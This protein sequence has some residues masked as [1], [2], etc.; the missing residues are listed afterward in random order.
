ME[1]V[2]DS[3][4]IGAH[5]ASQVERQF[6]C[7]AS[8]Q[9]PALASALAYIDA[10]NP[11]VTMARRF[12]AVLVLQVAGLPPCTICS[13]LL[14]LSQHSAK[15]LPGDNSSDDASAITNITRNA[16]YIVRALQDIV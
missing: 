7:L 11:I 16:F 5:T 6:C 13:R 8:P 15:A 3:S 14:S 12:W 10:T 4:V 1:K 9:L 2:V